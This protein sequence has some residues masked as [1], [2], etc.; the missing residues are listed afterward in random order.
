LRRRGILIG[1]GALLLLGALAL[2]WTQMPAKLANDYEARAEPQTERV[3]RVLEPAMDKFGFETFGV[4]EVKVKQSP[5]G[6]LRDLSRAISKDLRELERARSVVKRAK[7]SLGRIDEEAM[8]DAPSWPLLGGTDEVQSASGIAGEA[9]AYLR[10]ARAYVRE[11]GELVEYSIDYMRFS[12]KLAGAGARAAASTPKAPTSVEQV[13]RPLER[14]Q[15]IAI[16]ELL[17]FRRHK[18]PK[19]AFGEHHALIAQTERLIR[20]ERALLAAIRRQDQGSVV[21][22]TKRINSE[23]GRG[24][25]RSIKWLEK[26][27]D[28]SRY[29]RLIDDLRRREGRL[30]KGFEEL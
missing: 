22:I 8:T 16:A 21:R 27:M 5:R 2:Y 18:P 26:L 28:R 10:K 17:R 9:G 25:R 23:L 19:E 14:E 1:A 7:R 3:Q 4:V 15:R 30:R 12:Y 20:N 24:D 29:T 6:Y 11:F 13:T